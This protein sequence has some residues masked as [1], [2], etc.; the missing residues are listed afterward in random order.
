MIFKMFQRL[1]GRDEYSGTD[2]GLALCK[3][4]DE[5]HGGV[6]WACSVYGEG[7]TFHFTLPKQPASC[8]T[9]PC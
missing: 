3:R 9:F 8:L 5:R 1:H 6:L 4:I 7:T 2:I